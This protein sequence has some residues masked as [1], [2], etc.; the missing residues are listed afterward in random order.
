MRVIRATGENISPSDDGSLFQ[1]IL[2]NGLFEDVTFTSL[3]S[4]QVSVPALYG[5]LQ[6]REF[7]NAAETLSV[8]L[9]GSGT[10]TGYIYVQYD[11]AAN[12]IGTLE[13]ALAPFTP[14]LGEINSTDT[15]AQMVIATYTASA[16][17]VT[18][19]QPAYDIA[20]SHGSRYEADIT[21]AHTSWASD[22]ITITDA[23][24]DPSKMNILSYPA[25][26][27]D[28]EY[29]AYM[30][31]QIRPYGAITAGSMQ[32]KAVNGAPTIDLPLVLIVR[33]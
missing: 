18:D 24:I 1:N 30:N 12:P 5:I 23:H 26:L 27:S 33:N 28:S 11:L 13:S 29:E 2:D 14:V 6:G 10:A 15:V 4:N 17:A 8:V 16:I 3:G 32:L 7:T 9:P 25:T 20:V 22:L 21:L 19:I 31:A